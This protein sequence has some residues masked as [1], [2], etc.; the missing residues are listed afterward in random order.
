[1]PGRWQNMSTQYESQEYGS[2]RRHHQ[3]RLQIERRKALS[4]SRLLIG[5]GAIEGGV[6]TVYC[7]SSSERWRD[8]THT[9]THAHIRTRTRTHARA[10]L[11]HTLKLAR[12]NGTHRQRWVEDDIL[13]YGVYYTFMMC[14][15]GSIRSFPHPRAAEPFRACCY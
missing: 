3:A 2:T 7:S 10:H 9:H 12:D 11:R 8:F 1:M 4:R 13:C 6:A 14:H 15:R 5:W